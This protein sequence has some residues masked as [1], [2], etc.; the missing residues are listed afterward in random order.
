MSNAS[1]MKLFCF[2]KK[3]SVGYYANLRSAEKIINRFER[4]KA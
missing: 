4:H 3:K 1:L 2:V